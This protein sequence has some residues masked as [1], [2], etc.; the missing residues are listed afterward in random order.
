MAELEYNPTL[1]DLNDAKFHHLL[2]NDYKQVKRVRHGPHGEA[3]RKRRLG[4]K[5]ED[6]GNTEDTK[7]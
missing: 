2:S 4:K 7:R 5:N 6:G 3:G 1:R